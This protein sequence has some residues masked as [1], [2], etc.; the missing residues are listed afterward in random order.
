MHIPLF[1]K[2]PA[3]LF[4]LK[5]TLLFYSLYYLY[6]G[7]VALI[8]ER[9]LYYWN[10]PSDFNLIRILRETLKHPVSWILEWSGHDTYFSERGV[11]L[12]QGGGINISFS[13]L[14]VKVM[15]V[16]ISM[17]LAYPGYR[18][19]FFLFI[20]LGL[21]HLLNVSRM[22]AL[23]FMLV[24]HAREK[25]FIAHDVFNYGAYGIILLCFYIYIKQEKLST[26]Q[27]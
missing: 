7:Y 2:H 21:I 20:G 11:Y 12:R 14:G 13:C 22:A 3:V 27:G 24:H 17:I 10:V 23:L 1:L 8:D 6:L 25:A 26:L 16:Y 5:F 4:L 18:K 15:L 9:G 19:I